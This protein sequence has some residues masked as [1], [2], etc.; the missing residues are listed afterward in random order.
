MTRVELGGG[1]GLNVEAGGSGA[2]V[3]MLHGFTGSA[4]SWGE[5]GR[6][7]AERHTV[8]A[9]DIAGHG[10]SDAPAELE[11]YRME[12]A[13]EDIVTAVAQLGFARAVWVGYSMGGRTALQIAARSPEAV[14][15]LVLIGGSAGL[16]CVED[17]LARRAADDALAARIERD[18]VPAFVD[19]W[20][21]IPLFATQRA[22]APEVRA[23]IRGGRLANSARGLANS[24]RGMG[25]GAQEP[26][27]RRLGSLTM[28]ALVLAGEL[29]S[30][31]VA[32][33]RE[34]AAAIP[35]ARFMAIRGAGHAAHLEQPAACAEAV[36]TFTAAST[37]AIIGNA[38]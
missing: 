8:V 29:D 4:R 6:L 13:A 38:P 2:P 33:G 36:L 16:D 30:K 20:E 9:V 25:T 23:A 28:P 15:K 3:V 32:I 34:L 21:S 19:Y 31:F 26:L 17:R 12:Q 11:H 14:T 18:G 10:A 5:F 35:N 24:L 1:F 7:V 37:P 22:L 27:Q